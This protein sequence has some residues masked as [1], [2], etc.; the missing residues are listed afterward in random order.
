M[1]KNLVTLYA[2]LAG[3]TLIAAAACSDGNNKA[4]AENPVKAGAKVYE[5]N[6]KSCHGPGGKGDICPNLA[7]DE[8][9]YGSSDQDI[10]TTIAKGRPG[11]M[12]AWESTLGEKK[13]RDVIAYIRSLGK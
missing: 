9:K 11:G 13:I 2:V 10:Y 6:C 4:S 8:W 5:Q 12:P 3:I 1:G 7:D